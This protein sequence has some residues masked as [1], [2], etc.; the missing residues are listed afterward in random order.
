MTNPSK[1]EQVAVTETMVDRVARA[2]RAGGS[3]E[4]MARA[5][6][7]AMEVPTEEMVRAEMVKYV[8]KYHDIETEAAAEVAFMAGAEF[9]RAALKEEK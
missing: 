1:R 2:L 3:Y 8:S 9:V 5:A 4:D 6:I 7:A